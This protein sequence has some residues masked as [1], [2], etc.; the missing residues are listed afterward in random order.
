MTILEDVALEIS[1]LLVALFSHVTYTQEFVTPKYAFF[2]T[3]TIAIFVILS[4]RTAKDKQI[5]IFVTPMHILWLAFGFASLLS[6]VNVFKDNPLFFQRSFDISLYVLVN[7]FLSFHF[8]SRFDKKERIK[9]ILLVFMISGFVVSINA[10]L[11]YYTGYDIF[12]GVNGLPYDRGSIRASIGNVIFV[13][14]YLNMLLP[15]SLYITFSSSDIN[16]FSKNKS[17]YSIK[18]FSLMCSALYFFVVL[19]SQTRSEY[20][21]WI[22][23][24]VFF[25][26]FYMLFL[27]KKRHQLNIFDS[28]FKR[29]SVVFLILFIL[30]VSTLYNIPSILNN[31]SNSPIASRLNPDINKGYNDSIMIG[32]IESYKDLKFLGWLSTLY[33]WKNHKFL[34]Q[35]IGMYQLYG[36]QG[37]ANLIQDNPKYMYSWALYTRA[38]NDFLQVLAETGILGFAIVVLLFLLLIIYVFKVLSRT[39]SFDD[40]LMLT[41]FVCSIIIF[42]VQSMFSY[43]VQVLPNALLANFIISVGVGRYFNSMWKKEIEFTG[44]RAILLMSLVLMIS[45]VSATYRWSHFLSEVNYRLGRIEYLN[46]NSYRNGITSIQ[47]KIKE[48]TAK[49]NITAEEK[50]ELS[51]LQKKKFELNKL[52]LDSYEKSKKFLV[53]S[54]NLDRT[55]GY[56]YFFLAALSEDPIRIERVK[57]AEKSE[58]LKLISERNDIFQRLVPMSNLSNEYNLKH[59]KDILE[60]NTVSKETLEKIIVAQVTLDALN[61]LKTSILLSPEPTSYVLISE[62][63]SLLARIMKDLSNDKDLSNSIRN[64]TRNM[65]NKFSLKLYDWVK[66][67]LRILPGGWI[68]YPYFKSL[69]IESAATKGEDIYRKLASFVIRAEE[70]L[71]PQLEEKLLYI[72]QKEVKACLN[73]EEH[74]KW[75]IPD[76]VIYYLHAMVRKY[77]QL[78]ETEKAKQILSK[79]LD[80]YG[81]P[82]QVAVDKLKNKDLWTNNYRKTSELLYEQLENLLSKANTDKKYKEK[83][84]SEFSRRLKMSYEKLENFDYN[85]LIES[86][87][88]E[89]SKMKLQSIPDLYF[90]S[91]WKKFSNEY[92]GGVLYELIKLDKDGK[93]F[94]ESLGFYNSL[95]DPLVVSIMFLKERYSMFKSE[96]ELLLKDYN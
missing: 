19:I 2:T 43:P 21:S 61:L 29:F 10:I 1:I 83:V 16:D 94:N 50:K 38:H 42:V 89:L 35:G 11:N 28:K 9:S 13:A 17:E 80:L 30:I 48:L 63:Y 27:N 96:Y 72:A 59:F 14:N 22:V 55:Y 45:G 53:K 49:S 85:K 88:E 18:I 78:G 44:K 75:G 39:D 31:Y 3:F 34:G 74:R 62:R 69:D 32:S 8:S 33:I 65:A 92:L 77:K 58:F 81:K 73:A 70:D 57:N 54:I 12:T 87:V 7:I 79:M 26:L 47:G 37:I 40:S 90:N 60:N 93:I 41:C 36:L 84:L 67:T 24:L 20:L 56:S 52:I 66:E 15:I 6:T 68:S 82:Y 64:S 46:M 5:N 4:I 86:Y 51:D 71:T 76:G 91:V 95:T 25:A 23:T